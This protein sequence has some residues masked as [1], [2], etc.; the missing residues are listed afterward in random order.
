MQKK[1]VVRDVWTIC[2]RKSGPITSFQTGSKAE[3]A[4]RSEIRNTLYSHYFNIN[5]SCLL[6]KIENTSNSILGIGSRL[7][8]HLIRTSINLLHFLNIVKSLNLIICF[9]SLN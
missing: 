8:K 7:K 3:F 9:I 5:S 1:K 4:S 6:L 2:C